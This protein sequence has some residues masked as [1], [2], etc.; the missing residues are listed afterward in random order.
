MCIST[1]PTNEK[2][3]TLTSIKIQKVSLPSP[4]SSTRLGGLETA[5]GGKRWIPPSV[6]SRLKRLKGLSRKAA[7]FS[8]DNDHIHMGVSSGGVNIGCE[9][10]AM[11]EAK[12]DVKGQCRA[13]ARDSWIIPV[14]GL[15]RSL[16]DRVARL[17]EENPWVVKKGSS[18]CV[19]SMA[20]S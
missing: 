12:R 5:Q 9:D 14:H 2:I 8:M 17:V 10:G 3:L 1:N 15:L 20:S 7:N 4:S 18:G 16:A 11:S 13:V 6:R 19:R